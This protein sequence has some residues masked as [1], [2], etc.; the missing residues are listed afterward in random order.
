MRSE[1]SRSR[2]A[3]AIT[4][5]GAL[6]A[7][8]ASV[9]V[10][11]YVMSRDQASAPQPAAPPVATSR[12]AARSRLLAD[13]AALLAARRIGPLL[14][15]MAA[16]KGGPIE[17]YTYGREELPLADAVLRVSVDGGRPEVQRPV[18]GQ[19]CYR[20]DAKPFTG[21][22]TELEVLLEASAG[23]G[24][25]VTFRLP[26][27]LPP[28]AA[29]LLERAKRTMLG[30]RTLRIDEVL[31]AGAKP[32]RSTWLIEAPGRL[33]VSSSDG[34]STVLIGTRRWDL[35]DGSWREGTWDGS[36]Q[37]W[38]A[39]EDATN[40][41]LL[42]TG[43]VEGVAVSRLAAFTPDPQP[44]WFTLWVADDG[45]VL[46]VEMLAAS[47]F[48]TDRYSAFDRPVTIEPPG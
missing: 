5:S 32:V 11:G 8:L 16:R 38:Y 20:I 44:W 42:G 34:G 25:T 46:K 30:V 1:P 40:A 26:A 10:A 24:G 36:R 15:G 22:A 43:V 41:R 21:E 33:S 29:A 19:G 23:R 14:V 13:P 9:A 12:P 18:C 28:S 47:H 7:I 37:P 48:M 3:D 27:S 45:R 6:I 31:S 35:I 2:A 39:W 4:L 17:L